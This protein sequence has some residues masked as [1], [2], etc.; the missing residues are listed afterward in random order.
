MMTNTNFEQLIDKVL[1]LL[2][3]VLSKPSLIFEEKVI[4]ENA[5]HILVG[6]LIFKVEIYPKFVNFASKT[7]VR[8]AEEIV[9]TGL[10][11]A[12]QKVR[13]DFETSLDA[14]ASGMSHKQNALHFLLGIVARNFST[15]SNKPSQQFFKLFNRLIDLKSSRDDLLGEST[16]DSSAIYNPEELLN[17]TIDKIKQQQ[18]DKIQQAAQDDHDVDEVKAMELAADQERLLVGLITL[19]GK[20]IAKADKAVSDRIIQEKDLIA[21]IFRDFL[22]A[23]YYQAREMSSMNEAVVLQQKSGSRQ[24]KKKVSAPNNKSR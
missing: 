1:L 14:L 8:N 12:E 4:V 17:Q 6:T 10:L 21:Q 24:D 5:L 15:I 3:T 7:G 16:E 9:L 13:I 19:T 11:N 23:S 18:R 2:S 22:F 20:I